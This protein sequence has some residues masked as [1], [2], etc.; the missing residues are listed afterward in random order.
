MPTDDAIF[1]AKLKREMPPKRARAAAEAQD[2]TAQLRRHKSATEEAFA[3]VVCPITHSLPIDPVTAEDGNV[4]ERSAIEEWLKWQR[5]SP[6]TNLAMSTRLQPALRVKNMIRVM[7]ASG[8]LT[9][10]MVDAW[11]IKLANEAETEPEEEEE[12]EEDAA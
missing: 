11:S 8:A 12:E 9:G 7:V 6:M 3:E 4:Y 2:E 1:F 10:P 5:K